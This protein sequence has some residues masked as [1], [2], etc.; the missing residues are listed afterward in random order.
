M[1]KGQNLN[2]FKNETKSLKFYA[3]GKNGNCLR[4]LDY[5][6]YYYWMIRMS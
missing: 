4:N 3:I 6:Y 5:Y 2:F 1:K